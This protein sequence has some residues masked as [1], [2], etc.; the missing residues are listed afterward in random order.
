MKSP[1]LPGRAALSRGM[2]TRTSP[3][4]DGWVRD[5]RVRAPSRMRRIVL[6]ASAASMLSFTRLPV[7]ATPA[8][9]KAAIDAWT[10]G[11]PLREGRVT[12]DVPP[13]VDNGNLVSVT[14]RVASP[15]TP[16][17]H[18]R[19]IA[20]FNDGN[21]L[22]DVARFEL[23]PRSGRAEVSIG[24]RLMTTQQLVAAARMSDGTFWHQR[25]EVVVVLAACIE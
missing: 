8:S 4:L 5:G 14:V 12:F 25:V 2:S 15:M 21:P 23:S 6:A 11:A 24:I 18:V 20:I 10:G 1:H 9:M 13:L 3:S 16:A 7:R 19:E 17:D 22:P